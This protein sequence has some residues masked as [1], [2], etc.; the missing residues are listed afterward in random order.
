MAI[1][2]ACSG[3][4]ELPGEESVA[5]AAEKLEVDDVKE[6]GGLQC[7]TTGE[8]AVLAAT[9]DGEFYLHHTPPN[10]G[11]KPLVVM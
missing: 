1:T 4:S 6:V 3:V 8:K 5:I 9:A 11:L 2:E 7:G 10:P